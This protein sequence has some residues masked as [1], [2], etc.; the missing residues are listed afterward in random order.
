M[1]QLTQQP[2]TS[3][4]NSSAATKQPALA[5]RLLLLLRLDLARKLLQVEASRQR[6][7]PRQVRVLEQSLKKEK[8]KATDELGK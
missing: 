5:F 2:T 6:G 7:S 8:V 1:P 3:T 4:F